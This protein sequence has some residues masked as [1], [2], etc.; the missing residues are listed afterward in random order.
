MSKLTCTSSPGLNESSIA[1]LSFTT[2]NLMSCGNLSC[3]VVTTNSRLVNPL[4]NVCTSP[5]I[6]ILPLASY[7]RTNVSARAGM[8]NVR[9]ENFSRN[10]PGAALAGAGLV[11]F[12]R[13]H[14]AAAHQ[15]RGWNSGVL[16]GERWFG[17]CRVAFV[18]GRWRWQLGG[19]PELPEH[20]RYPNDHP[21]QKGAADDAAGRNRRA[22]EI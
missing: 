5:I 3:A 2:S 1:H 4:P 11:A 13:D 10:S 17:S 19:I 6:L 22:H 14:G 18:V 16:P 15:R 7:M 12:R 9:T 21:D 20:D 8:S